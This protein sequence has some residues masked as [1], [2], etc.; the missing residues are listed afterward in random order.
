MLTPQNK[1]SVGGDVRILFGEPEASLRHAL[2][3]ALN[4]EGFEGVKDFDRFDQLKEA[5]LKTSPDLI[6]L[7]SEMDTGEADSLITDLR[8]NRLGNNPFVPVIVTIW[9]PTRDQ[10]KRVASSGTD[11]MLVKP[12]SPSQVFDRIK[13]LINNRKPFVV[14]SDYIGPDRRKDVARGS[15]IPTIDVPNTL[16]SKVK[17]EK[18]D[19]ADIVR[20]VKEAQA[21]INDQRLKR[22]AFQISFLITLLMPELEKYEVTDERIKTVE[23]LMDVARDTGKRMKGTE[24]EHVTSLCNALIRVASSIN[25]S[26][27]HP[28]TKDVSL[29]KPMSEAIMAA[30]NPDGSSADFAGQ[31][32]SAVSK[33]KE[34]VQG[35]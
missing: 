33:Y 32:S 22:N 27:S 4:R 14:T 28:E 25:D 19:S 16:R 1:P 20:A 30:F 26:I 35:G 34:R 29:L 10:V 8:Y 31:I 13:A 15:E 2:R 12:L 18:V 17:G 23:R 6:M 7:D 24:Y 3:A 11:D 5:I 9:E 21:E